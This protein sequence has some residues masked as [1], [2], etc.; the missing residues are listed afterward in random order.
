MIERDYQKLNSCLLFLVSILS[1][2]HH[3]QVTEALKW[4][5]I[6]L[7]IFVASFPNKYD[8]VE[9]FLFLLKYYFTPILHSTLKRNRHLEIFYREA[10]LKNFHV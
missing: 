5:S 4:V 9:I 1:V 8:G 3:S 6:F 7:E 10:F 2:F